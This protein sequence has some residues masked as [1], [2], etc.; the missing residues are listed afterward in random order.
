MEEY[1]EKYV[2]ILDATHEPI[3][4]SDKENPLLDGLKEQEGISIMTPEEF[5]EK[6]KDNPSFSEEDKTLFLEKIST[7][8]LLDEVDQTMMEMVVDKIKKREE[9]V[10]AMEENAAREEEEA[11]KKGYTKTHINGTLRRLD[12]KVGRNDACPCGSGLKYKK[13]HQNTLPSGS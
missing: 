1:K 7:L 2:A 4:V 11:N 3:M 12:R 5:L 10:K 8:I 13:C 9:A 6:M